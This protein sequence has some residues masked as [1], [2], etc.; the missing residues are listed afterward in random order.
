MADQSAW[1]TVAATAIPAATIHEIKYQAQPETMDPEIFRGT[2]NAAIEAW[3]KAKPAAAAAVE[4][5]RLARAKVAEICFPNAAKGTQR[6]SLGGGYNVKLVHSLTYKLGD[7]TL[8][9]G[10]G[11][12]V[13]TNQQIRE[14]RDRLY[15]SAGD[16]AIEDYRATGADMSNNAA[17]AEIGRLAGD[18]AIRT[19]DR[20]VT[21]KPECS[22]TEYEKLSAENATELAVRDAIS[23][24]LTIT[25]A[26]PQLTFE[27]PKPEKAK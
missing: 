7:A 8:L 6:Y 19:F 21:W 26:T 3:Q 13:P 2:R 16:K 1:P 20:V 5:E 23:E 9:D 12:K 27:E 17:V 18:E 24:I 25:P 10:E 22:G 4:I 14:T 11:K 15:R